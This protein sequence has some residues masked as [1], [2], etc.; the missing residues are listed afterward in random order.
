[1]YHLVFTQEKG[2]REVSALIYDELIAVLFYLNLPT[3]PAGF[4]PALSV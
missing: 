1:M 2:D 3:D 4:E